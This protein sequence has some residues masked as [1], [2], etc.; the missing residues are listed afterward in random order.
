[1]VEVIE[2][3]RFPASTYAAFRKLV[4]RKTCEPIISTSM[5]S[6]GAVA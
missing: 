4:L 1:M 2:F 5:Q 3:S 6:L